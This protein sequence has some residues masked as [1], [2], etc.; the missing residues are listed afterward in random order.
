MIF[1][2]Q[3]EGQLL[4]LFERGL[5]NRSRLIE[6]Q[7]ASLDVFHRKNVQVDRSSSCGV[8]IL[9][10]EVTKSP[11]HVDH[12]EYR[13]LPQAYLLPSYEFPRETFS[14]LSGS[15]TPPVCRVPSKSKNIFVPVRQADRRSGLYI[16]GIGIRIFLEFSITPLLNLIVSSLFFQIEIE[17][18]D[19]GDDV[20]PR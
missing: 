19:I 5:R 20:Y 7:N 4:H 15:E 18:F 10:L 13:C 1:S 2:G 12:F 14:R 11:T 17:K 3:K 6:F 9:F 8:T 16:V